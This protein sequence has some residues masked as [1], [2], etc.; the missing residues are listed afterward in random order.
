MVSTY[1]SIYK[2]ILAGA[3]FLAGL[4]EL[5]VWWYVG[6]SFIE[7]FSWKVPFLFLGIICGVLTGGYVWILLRIPFELTYRFDTIKNKVAL[8]EY[9]SVEA[10]QD[11]VAYLLIDFFKFPALD[12][13]G[14]YFKFSGA[15]P[16]YMNI[17]FDIDSIVKKEY[18]DIQIIDL[19][20]RR[21][22]FVIPVMIGGKRLGQM[23]LFTKGF[24][25]FMLRDMLSDF[26][27]QYL[28]DQLLHIIHNN[29]VTT[30]STVN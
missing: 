8:R 3:A 5:S 15:E 17:D 4:L 13:R 14:G 6:F 22:A 2:I 1:N 19:P 10:F 11:D 18:Y 28:D 29:S 23:V 7:S 24:T 20:E 12:I 27:N 21:K 25:L 30:I 9:Q 16:L 26:E